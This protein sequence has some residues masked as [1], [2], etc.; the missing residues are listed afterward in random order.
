M[1]ARGSVPKET[2][3]RGAGCRGLG[4]RQRNGVELLGNKLP[5]SPAASPVGIRIPEVLTRTYHR[6]GSGSSAYVFQAEVQ[7]G[8]EISALECQQAL[9][10]RPGIKHEP[11]K[12]QPTSAWVGASVSILGSSSSRASVTSS[13]TRLDTLRRGDSS[14]ERR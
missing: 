3:E 4:A 11:G 12:E 10:W 14:L 8:P 7:N 2:P 1:Y 5:T 13:H 6:M 9:Q